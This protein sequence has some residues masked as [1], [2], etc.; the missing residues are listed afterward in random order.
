MPPLRTEGRKPR[1]RH[2]PWRRRGKG[3]EEDTIPELLDDDGGVGELP[4]GPVAAVHLLQLGRRATPAAPRRRR[5][6]QSR[7]LHFLTTSISEERRNEQQSSLVWL[8]RRARA[9]G[10]RQTTH[11]RPYDATLWTGGG[12]SHSHSRSFSSSIASSRLR[13]RSEHIIRWCRPVAL[14]PCPIGARLRRWPANHSD[15]RSRYA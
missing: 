7:R 2:G 5:T 3:S 14:A 10:A 8:R 13:S 4:P 11:H 1:Q 9:R 15:A 6:R 12:A